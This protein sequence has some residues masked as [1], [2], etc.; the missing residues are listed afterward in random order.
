MKSQIITFLIKCPDS[1]GLVARITNYFYKQGF[2]IVSCQQHVNS[3]EKTY[4]MR[5]RLDAEGTEVSKKELEENFLS[6]AKTLNLTWSVNYGTHKDNVAIMVSHTSHCLYDLL[7]REREG[8]LDC[9][10]KMV[11][12]NHN[13]LRPVAEMFGVPYYHLPVDK[14]S[15]SKQEEEVM[16]LLEVN[17]IDLVVMARYMQ[18]LSANFI[19]SYPQKIINIHHSFLPAFQGANPESD[20]SC[21]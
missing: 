8:G 20:N 17:K 5:I 9:N 15:K 3:I 10:I 6:F 7:E 4:F 16:R 2:N 19:N 21:K 18:I 11:I 13:K 1:K 12:S 14:N